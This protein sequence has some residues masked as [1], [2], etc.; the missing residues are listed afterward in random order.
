MSGYFGGYSYKL[1]ESSGFLPAAAT[2][3]QG[4]AQFE[5]EWFANTLAYATKLGGE[6][7]EGLIRFLKFEEASLNR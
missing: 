2:Q 4:Q 1:G 6:W 7:L 3:K 5:P